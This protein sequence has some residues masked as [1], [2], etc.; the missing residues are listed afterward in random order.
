MKSYLILFFS[1]LSMTVF[2]KEVTLT[3]V[4]KE[5]T[6]ETTIQAV[7]IEIFQG[8]LITTTYSDQK[9]KIQCQLTK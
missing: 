8:V 7:K 6:N 9:G 3:G 5:A 4:V 2:A 1:M